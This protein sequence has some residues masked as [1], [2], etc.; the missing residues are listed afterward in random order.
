MFARGR[1]GSRA[2]AQCAVTAR[3]MGRFYVPEWS[4]RSAG[5]VRVVP[6]DFGLLRGGARLKLSLVASFRFIERCARAKGM[7]LAVGDEIFTACVSLDHAGEFAASISDPE[8]G[9]DACP[10]HRLAC[11]V[12]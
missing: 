2:L 3:L 5:L 6:L 4:I 9:L 10:C 1:T 8:S 7:S 12:S 11:S